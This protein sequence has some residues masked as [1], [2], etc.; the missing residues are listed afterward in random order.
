M[1]ITGISI[2]HILRDGE[3]IS[4]IA[5]TFDCGG[6]FGALSL[7]LPEEWSGWNRSEKVAWGK[8]Q[9]QHHLESHDYSIPHGL[10]FPDKSAITT[11]KNE[12]QDLPGWAMWTD[13]EAAAWIEQNVNSLAEAKQVLK[14]MAQAVIYLRDIVIE[15]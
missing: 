4:M 13:A 6:S 5:V 15:R 14:K 7:E 2:N 1:W 11:A 9:V 10:V 8:Q 3:V 12:F